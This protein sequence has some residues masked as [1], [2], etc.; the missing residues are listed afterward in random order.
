MVALKPLYDDFVK[1]GPTL[2]LITV[3]AYDHVRLESTLDS[4]C[5]LS[6][7]AEVVVVVPDTDIR[8]IEIVKQ[9]SKTINTQVHLVFDVGA[10]I[11]S[12][13]N[14]G[15]KKASGDYLTYWNSGDLCLDVKRLN[16]FIDILDLRRPIWGV[17]GGKFN[18]RSS[19][20]LTPLNVAKF[21][22]QRGGYISHQTVFVDRIVFLDM[23][24][25]DTR[26]KI[27]ADTK[28]ISIL[29]ANF[30]CDLLDFEIVQIEQ[31][32]VSGLQNRRGRYE[33]VKVAYDVLPINQAIM[34]TVYALGREAR[35]LVAKI[36]KRIQ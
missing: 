20:E 26:Y 24:G 1:S 5:D 23:G 19:Q 30:D 22:L 32:G 6:N 14:T 7:R 25:F 21:V 29:W 27:A 8:S 18:W 31:P 34:A 3:S 17:F 4:Y 9:Y 2:T 10:G 11:Y 36:R 28:V 33:C 16:E 13:M 12:A 35:Y 15:A